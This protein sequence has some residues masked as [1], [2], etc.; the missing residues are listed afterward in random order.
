M[1]ARAKAASVPGMI[2]IHWWHF[3]AVWLR[4]GSMQ[5][6]RA[7]RRFASWH[8]VQKCRLATTGLD[9]QITISFASTTFSGSMPT[10][11]PRVSAMPAVPA[12]EQI[13]R[14]RSEAPSLWKKRRSIDA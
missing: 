13:V 14:S 10:D 8:R 4:Q 3:C 2:G 5:I 12:D 6:R 1:T 7:P 11:A 9:P